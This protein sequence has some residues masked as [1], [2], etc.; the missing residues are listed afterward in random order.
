MSIFDIGKPKWFKKLPN[1][2]QPEESLIQ[3]IENFR[4]N[5]GF[6][7]NSIATMISMSPWSVKKLQMFMYKKFKK[8]QP[9]WPEKEIWRYV[10]LSRMNIKL[11][12]VDYPP[13]LGSNPLTRDEINSIVEKSEEIVQGFDSFDDLVNYILEIDYKE[14]RFYDPSRILNELNN[15]LE[16]K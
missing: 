16:N 11:M 4:I 6:D 13:D 2:F 14:N 10:L 1:H 7:H 15:L 8:E 3:E 5:F 9:F 12:T